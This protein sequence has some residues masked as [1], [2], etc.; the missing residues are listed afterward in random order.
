VT[1]KIDLFKVEF[2]T[3]SASDRELVVEWF[4]SF[5]VTVALY[6]LLV[7][8]KSLGTFVDSGR[9]SEMPQLSK[10]ISFKL[11]M[12][13]T[14][15]HFCTFIVNIHGVPQSLAAPAFNSIS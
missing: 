1:F 2:N 8:K 6:F 5:S 4:S 15:C 13:M 7:S 14:M 9:I 12:M 10:R 3:E 11:L